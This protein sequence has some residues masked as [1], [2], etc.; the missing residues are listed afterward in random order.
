MRA[1]KENDEV[2][3]IKLLEKTKNDRLSQL[4]R[5]TDEYLGQIGALVREAK[6]KD[7]S[8]GPA[9]PEASS[10]DLNAM[11]EEEKRRL[12]AEEEEQAKQLESTKNRY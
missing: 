12:M 9:L 4:L 8:T 11:T 5:Q 3:Y 1:L 6:H 7:E 10:I 2:A